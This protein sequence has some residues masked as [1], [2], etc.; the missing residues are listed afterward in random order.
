MTESSGPSLSPKMGSGCLS[1][2]AWEF[3]YM[4]ICLGVWLFWM[5]VCAHACTRTCMFARVCTSLYC[6][7]HIFNLSRSVC[8]VPRGHLM[9]EPAPCLPAPWVPCSF[10]QSAWLLRWPPASEESV[11]SCNCLLLNIFHANGRLIYRDLGAVYETPAADCS[12]PA[13]RAL[14]NQPP[15]PKASW[16]WYAMP[17]YPP[18]SGALGINLQPRC[19]HSKQQRL[20]FPPE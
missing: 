14:D 8:E 19:G 13:K 15:L 1:A 18:T 12:F 4:C 17:P 10:M 16:T 5:C 9:P 20:R 11:N 6:G 3:A 2:S 7:A